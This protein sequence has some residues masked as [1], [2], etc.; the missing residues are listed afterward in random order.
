MFD[1]LIRALKSMET[2]QLTVSIAADEEGYLDRECPND[3]C[4]AVFKVFLEDWEREENGDLAFCCRCGHAATGDKWWTTEQAEKLNAAMARHV[5]QAMASALERDARRFNQGQRRSA[6][7]RMELQIKS[8]S[9]PP[10]IDA[11]ARDL[12]EQK[13]SCSACSC[14]YACV[15][16]PFFCP[17]CGEDDPARAF[18]AAI[19]ATRAC[20]GRLPEF[21]QLVAADSGKDIAIDAV[22]VTLENS[23]AKLVGA[24]EG[25]CLGTFRR[26]PEAAGVVLAQGTF[27][28]LDDGSD[29]WVGVGRSSYVDVLGAARWA[30]LR[31]LYQRRHLIAH[32]EGVVDQRYID[33]SGDTAYAVGQRVVVRAQDVLELAE[34]L[35]LLARSR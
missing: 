34:M 3:E 16:A 21:E 2:T 32:R 11:R 23:M 12:M 20:L 10:E 29:L 35:E 19:D 5:Q 9:L 25:F 24:F 26:L 31:V 7:I 14:R 22:R 17:L 8:P 13:V 1:E 15:G 27:Q 4:Q 28:R 18:Q 33:R 6:F 30:R